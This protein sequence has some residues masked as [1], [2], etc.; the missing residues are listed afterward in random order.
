MI[1]PALS[2]API[3]IALGQNG[4]RGRALEEAGETQYIACFQW[5]PSSVNGGSDVSW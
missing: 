1:D 4:H 2:L 5:H 3:D